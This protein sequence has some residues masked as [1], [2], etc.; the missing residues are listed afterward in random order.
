MTNCLIDWNLLL[1][2]SSKEEAAYF[3]GFIDDFLFFLGRTS[4]SQHL[5]TKPISDLEDSGF[6]FSSG[7]FFDVTCPADI[8]PMDVGYIIVAQK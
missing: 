4:D 5:V 6:E 1:K 7:H 8:D 2:T 3:K